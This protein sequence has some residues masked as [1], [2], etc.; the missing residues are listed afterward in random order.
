MEQYHKLF[1]KAE[2]E[3]IT[4]FLKLWMSFNNWYK[5]DLEEVKTDREAINKY[6]EHGKIKDEFLRLFDLSSEEGMS[7]NNAL[8]KLIL[9]LKSYDLKNSKGNVNYSCVEENKDGRNGNYIFISEKK[10]RF[11]ILEENKKL[12]FEETLDVFYCIRSNLV[13]GSFDIENE[14]FNKLI[15]SSYKILQPIMRKVLVLEF[16]EI[17]NLKQ[18]NEK[19]RNENKALKVSLKIAKLQSGESL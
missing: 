6:K 13:H 2:I 12:F 15:E 7:F 16:D 19:L 3:Y 9:N 4:P 1:D 18:E 10:E 11:Q 5:E 8:F 14:F 17:A